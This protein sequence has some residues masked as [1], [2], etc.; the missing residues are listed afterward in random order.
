MDF[1]LGSTVQDLVYQTTFQTIQR[2]ARAIS[3]LKIKMPVFC[4]SLIHIKSQV[5][6]TSSYHEHIHRLRYLSSATTVL[7]DFMCM[8][9]HCLQWDKWVLTNFTT[10]GSGLT[11]LVH[12]RTSPHRCI[13]FVT[14]SGTAISRL[15]GPVKLSVHYT[16]CVTFRLVPLK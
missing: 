15:S 7:L 6:D 11:H 9:N 2:G 5:H 10:T 14:P 8:L 4:S 1:W 12:R 13:L 3:N 16:R